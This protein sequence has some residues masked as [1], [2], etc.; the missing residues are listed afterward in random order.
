MAKHG[1]LGRFAR[2]ELGDSLVL[3]RG[4]GHRPWGGVVCLGCSWSGGVAHPDVSA[5]VGLA[6]RGK[7]ET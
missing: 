1:Q 4:V 2:A 3:L 5:A 7:G 6:W